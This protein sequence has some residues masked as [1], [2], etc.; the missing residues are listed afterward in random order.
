MDLFQFLEDGSPLT[1]EAAS[2]PANWRGVCRLLNSVLV[3]PYRVIKDTC[4]LWVS[5][6]L[7]NISSSF[8]KKQEKHFSVAH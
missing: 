3:F 4:E 6:S 8:L 5:E 2:V 7:Q 1:Q